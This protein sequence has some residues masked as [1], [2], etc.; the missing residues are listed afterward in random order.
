MF[1]LK[2]E[3]SNAAFADD[4][5]GEVARIL[6]ELALDLEVGLLNEERLEAGLLDEGSVRDLNGNKVGTWRVTP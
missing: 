3:T 5:C 6:R 2:I 4:P 1:T